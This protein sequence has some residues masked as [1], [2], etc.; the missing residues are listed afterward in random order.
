MQTRLSLDAQ[1]NF[2]N[3]TAGPWSLKVLGRGMQGMKVLWKLTTTIPAM[4]PGASF[5]P[6]G[7]AD[8]PIHPPPCLHP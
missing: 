7:P 5:L 4:A 2:A 6:E 8:A 3:L 1:R